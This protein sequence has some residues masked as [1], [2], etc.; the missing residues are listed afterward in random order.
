MQEHYGS[1]VNLLSCWGTCLFAVMESVVSLSSCP[2]LVW[3]VFVTAGGNLVAQLHF[4]NLLLA[5][6]HLRV[7]LVLTVFESQQCSL[8][9]FSD[10]VCSCCAQLLLIRKQ[11]KLQLLH[12]PQCQ[13]FLYFSVLSHV[14]WTLQHKSTFGAVGFLALLGNMFYINIVLYVECE[15]GCL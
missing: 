7:I 1:Y 15:K 9:D 5:Y 14:E 12:K 13:V 11:F 8:E 10:A 3:G 2:A 6:L 4:P